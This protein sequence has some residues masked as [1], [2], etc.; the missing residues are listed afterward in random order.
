MTH[1]ALAE[2]YSSLND[3]SS[4]NNYLT[5]NHANLEIVDKLGLDESLQFFETLQEEKQLNERGM[6]ILGYR[7]LWVERI[8]DTI[9]VFNLNIA[10]FPESW[11]VYDSLAEAYMI[12]GENDKAVKYYQKSLEI[13]P[14][15]ENAKKKLNELNL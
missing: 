7:L 9:R 10:A 5:H 12:A 11:N 2:P 14:D 6:N 8:N 15:N 1:L 4:A 13:N 3:H